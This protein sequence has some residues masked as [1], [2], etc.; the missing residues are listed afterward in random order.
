MKKREYLDYIQ[1]IV[2][3]IN[4]IRSFTKGIDFSDFVRYL[5]L[6]H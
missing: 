5:H 1:D 4:D 2:E 6:N 3:S